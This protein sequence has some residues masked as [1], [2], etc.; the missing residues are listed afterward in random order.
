MSGT[1]RARGAVQQAAA[2][3]NS[4]ARQDEGQTIVQMVEA[5]KPAL[6]R[7]F[8]SEKMS[9]RFVRVAITVIRTNPGLQ[10]CNPQSLLAALMLSAQLNL[11]PG[12]LGHVYYV[13]F[14]REVTFVVGYKGLIDL[15]RR[16][17]EIASIEARAVREHD[18]FDYCY[19]LESRLY[20]KPADDNRGDITHVYGIAKFKDGGHYY[21]V[22]SVGDIEQAR[23]Q[24]QTGRNNKGPWKDHYE[25]MARKTVIR[26]MAPYLP[27]NVEAAQAIEADEATVVQ[28]TADEGGVIDVTLVH[29]DDTDD[30][31]DIDTAD[32]E[33]RMVQ[34]DR[35]AAKAEGVT[36]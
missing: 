9:D 24:S 22:L 34:A 5:M 23:Q 4:P 28:S 3:T 30:T 17:G 13:P 20:H 2:N 31:D 8:A 6:T 10:R 32:D 1:D 15:A 14:G 7:L 33:D 29:H 11:E 21:D 35:E 27:L 16:S 26:R 36:S 25:A 18:E 19:G 12:P